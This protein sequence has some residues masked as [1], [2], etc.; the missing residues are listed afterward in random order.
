MDNVMASLRRMGRLLIFGALII[1]TIAVGIY[2]GQQQSSEKRLQEDITKLG[3]TLAKPLPAAEKLQQQYR[4]VTG[5]L[6]PISMKEALD[7]VIDIAEESGIDVSPEGNKLRIPPQDTIGKE[8]VG[9]GTYQVLA[10]NGVT[11]QGTHETVMA[12][13][14]NLEA[15]E[16]L[17]SLVIKKVIIGQIQ[18]LTKSGTGQ[19]IP[20]AMETVATLN[21]AIYT[22]GGSVA[23]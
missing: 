2:Y 23:Q 18:T 19:E 6:A 3:L 13:I 22:R 12:F 8:K 1:I 21:V 11:V 17:H 9:E 7:T 5:F 15:R 14:G 16:K 4:E 20:G 10:V